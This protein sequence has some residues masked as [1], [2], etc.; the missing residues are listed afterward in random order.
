MNLTLKDLGKLK[1]VE[2]INRE[3]LK[4]KRVSGVSTDSRTIQ[5]GNLFFALRGKK[6]DGHQFVSDVA[7]RGAIAVVVDAL[8]SKNNRESIQQLTH[9]LVVVPDT[10]NALG[11]LAA[12]YR[13]KF[14]IPVL[15]VGGSNGK[16]TTKE[17]ISV[18]LKTKYSVLSTEGN[19]NNHIGVPQMLFRLTPKDDIAVLELGT[20]HFGE[21][22]YLCDIVKPTHALI[23]NIGKEHLE[24]FGDEV[25]VARE[26]TELFRSVGTKGFAFINADDMHCVKAGKQ[27]SRSLKYGMSS[28][29]QIRAT[30]IRMTELGQPVFELTQKGIK[31]KSSIHLSVAG[32]HNVINALAAAAVGVKFK[33]PEKKIV[34][35]LQGWAATNKR[36]E[37]IL[38]NGITI[39]NDTYNANPDSVLAALKTL[40]SMRIAGKKIVVLADMLE[41]GE[42]AE[43]EHAKTGLAVTDSEF[44]YLLTFGPLSRF[45]HEA[46]KLAFAE[47]FDSKEALVNALKSQLAAG[48]A[49]L[50]KGSRGMKMEEI[51]SQI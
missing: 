23:T 22:K 45:T 34:S 42:K 12:L 35:A 44:E 10:T 20:N 43:H 1:S 50:V 30:D 17:L 31:K 2:I 19:L 28:T 29:A 8:W 7:G 46:S 24:F 25:G 41:L 21:L 14:S 40:Q 26:E 11:E 49:V 48:D 33:I 6:F 9:C 15:V 4:G 5:D 27:V 47:H 18:V 39:L 38:R 32:R 37:I 16:T 36:M 13:Q 51:V 3:F